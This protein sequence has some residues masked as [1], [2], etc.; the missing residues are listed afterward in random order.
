MTS[1]P[2][3]GSPVGT[4]ARLSPCAAPRS[5]AGPGHGGASPR[6]SRC[7][8][9]AA[10]RSVR[11]S[12]PTALDPHRLLCGGAA[13]RGRGAEGRP[14]AGQLLSVPPDPPRPPRPGPSRPSSSPAEQRAA[15]RGGP[16]AP[17]SVPARG[18]GTSGAVGSGGGQRRNPSGP[19][20]VSPSSGGVFQLSQTTSGPLSVCPPRR[21]PP[22][23]PHSLNPPYHPPGSFPDPPLLLCLFPSLPL[24]LPNPRRHPAC[25]LALRNLQHSLHAPSAFPDALGGVG[26]PSDW[27]GPV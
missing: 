4:G 19:P 15:G 1:A 6:C 13:A 7:P 17:S 27:R 10:G 11:H 12:H 22:A 14:E 8:E 9:G 24:C 18:C 5:P 21:C 2:R 25:P 16:T 23:Q 20:R 3:W 26:C